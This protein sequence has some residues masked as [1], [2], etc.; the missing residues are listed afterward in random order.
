MV[1]CPLMETTF[2]TLTLAPAID[3]TVRVDAPLLVPGVCRAVDECSE[4]GGKGLNVARMLARLGRSVAAGGLLGGDDAAPFERAM[5]EAGIS[6]RF[7]RVPGATRR[8]LMLVG[9]DGAE[10]KV[11]FPAFPELAFDE[12]LLAEAVGRAAEG[13]AAAVVSGSLPQRF[14]ARAAADAVRRLHALGKTVVL[15]VSGEA[16]RLAAAEAPAIIKPNREEAAGLLGRALES[17]SDLREACRA[18]AARHEVVVLS[19]GGNGAYFAGGGALWRVRAPAVRVADTTAAGDMML[20]AFC[21][22]YFPDRALRP[23][24]MVRAVAAGSAAAELPSSRVP[25]PAR[26]AALAAL[27]EAEPVRD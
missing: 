23:E 4:P 24:A 11:N 16:L 17:D 21:A 12:D 20:G 10:R 25:D 6:D 15:D 19:D 3:R 2:A 22:A 5:R 26:I 7:V 13:A 27:A 14:P 9:T 18:L 1:E 8:N